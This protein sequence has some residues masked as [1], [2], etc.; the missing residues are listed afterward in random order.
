MK[1][2]G[3]RHIY[4]VWQ[5]VVAVQPTRTS[6]VTAMLKLHD[7]VV[8]HAKFPFPPPDEGQSVGFTDISELDVDSLEI[9]WKAKLAVRDNNLVRKLCDALEDVLGDAL[10]AEGAENYLLLSFSPQIQFDERGRED[11]DLDANPSEVHVSVSTNPGCS[12]ETEQLA[13]TWGR[14]GHC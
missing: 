5:S 9:E 1:E 14:V 10:L 2:W 8:K 7:F 11:S 3:V 13:D 6:S 4:Q 12:F